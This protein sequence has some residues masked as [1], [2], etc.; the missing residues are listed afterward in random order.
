PR[1]PRRGA[2]VFT[3]GAGSGGSASWDLRAG[4]VSMMRF[5]ACEGFDA[6][7]F[8]ARGFGGSSMPAAML[9]AE[10]ASPPVV[11][12]SEAVLDLDR[13]VLYA[14]KTS[15]VSAVNLIGWSWGAD[16]AGLY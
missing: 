4:G 8:D 16:V 3:H 11:R 13:V 14:M 10:E 12:A 6:Y 1:V 15:S 2:V 5:L 7:A 9:G